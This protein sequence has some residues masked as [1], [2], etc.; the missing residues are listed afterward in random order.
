LA[1]ILGHQFLGLT[2]WRERDN[3]IVKIDGKRKKAKMRK[4]AKLKTGSFFSRLFFKNQEKLLGPQVENGQRGRSR[5]TH[6]AK[7]ISGRSALLISVSLFISLFISISLFLFAPGFISLSA[8]QEG[9]TPDKQVLKPFGYDIFRPLAEPI[10]EGPVDE[11]Y[12]LSP[13]DEI[14]ITVWGQLNL[15]YPL[16]VSEDGFIDIPDEGGRIFTNGV[17]LKE[18]K[19]LVTES[20]SRIYSSYIKADNPAESTAFVDVKLAK[21]RKLLVYVVGEVQNQ[22]A[23]TISSGVATLLNVLNNAGGIKETGSLRDIRIRRANGSIDSVDLYDFL[24]TGKMDVKKTR[25]LYGDYV[26]VPLKGKSVTIQGEIKR[27]GVY[28]IIGNEGIKELIRFAG[29]LTSNAYLKRVQV[30]RFEINV[31]EKFIDLDLESILNDPGKN[32]PLNDGDEITIF[33]TIVVRRPMVEVQGEGIKRPGIYEYFPGMTLKDLIEKA[34]GLKEDVYLDRADLVR[35]E[36]DFSKKLTS[37]SLRDLYKEETPGKFVFSGNQE[38]N[39]ALKEM[40]QIIIYSAYNFRGKDKYVTLEGHVKQPGRY[41]MPENMTLYD[42]IFSR[43]GFQDESFKKRAYLDLAHVFR[44][45][46]GET[47]ERIIS[48]NLGK[49]LEGD[50]SQN[51]KLENG[52]RIVIYTYEAMKQKPYVTIEGLV[53]RP[54]RYDFAEGLTLE[55]L[56]LIAGGL[57]P[58]ALKVEAVVAR[59]IATAEARK[60][61]TYVIPIAQDFASLPPEKKNALTMFD[62]VVIRNLPE[63]EPLPVV[64]ITGEVNFPGSYSLESREER[65][66]SL[67]R[68][69]G[70]LKK[71]AFPEGAWLYRRKDILDMRSE[72]TS[73]TERIAFNLAK[74]IQ[75][76][77]SDYDLILKDGDRIYVPTNPGNVEVKGAVR[78]PS[79]FHYQKG[80][81][82]NYYINLSG[83][84]TSEAD[85]KNI[86]VYFPD[87]TAK[88]KGNSIFGSLE[89]KPGCV[90]EVPYK[91]SKEIQVVEV[92]GAVK[93]PMIIQ[94]RKNER[95]RYYLDLCGGLREDADPE[96]IM[97][98]LPDGRKMEARGTAYF[99]P[100]IEPGAIIEVP[101]K[102]QVEK[103]TGG[104]VEVRGAVRNPMLVRFREGESLDYYLAFC[105][106]PREDA[107]MDNIIVHFA[108]GRTLERKGAKEF[109]PQLEPGA[110]IEVPV[111]RK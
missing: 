51:I 99:N 57:R 4:A 95:L 97:V 76:P 94:L 108:D 49:L 31:G 66:S 107:D 12:L 16:T 67:I 26:I 90:I 20:L 14:I 47:G 45:V 68:R 102:G 60:V 58:E 101:F 50:P 64:T 21:L 74:A 11:N 69:C 2:K 34:E 87:G 1:P 86:V 63:W 110:I 48:F 84:L 13:G 24:L 44:K 111:K 98:H 96:G 19:A 28:E 5:K 109:K 91:E 93:V 71:E 105:G 65:V 72:A 15:K 39:F 27:P 38:K 43:G 70:G 35:T 3:K 79:R 53:K 82:I 18:L 41:I 7:S 22:G 62:E 36:E 75:N 33:S 9:R 56:I 88:R 10:L 103:L 17:S 104:D 61:I 78:N 73:E 6:L 81:G 92:R 55:D 80:K 29:G 59:R 40:D 32:F 85:K 83:G 23:Y 106:G 52:D 89:I 54:G 77:G 25:I 37:F 42:L 8:A 46:S 30:R 100:Y